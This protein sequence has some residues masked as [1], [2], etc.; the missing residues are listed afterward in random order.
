MDNEEARMFKQSVLF[1]LANPRTTNEI[2]AQ[3]IFDLADG[4]IK[5]ERYDRKFNAII[6]TRDSNLDECNRCVGL[7]CC[8]P[9]YCWKGGKYTILLF[10][11]F[12]IL[13][14]F[15]SGS[16]WIVSRIYAS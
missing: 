5:L 14:A 4:F 13:F 1:K 10:C 6:T 15:F 3:Q 8:I 16:A 12:V 2:K 11:T 7:C 9:R